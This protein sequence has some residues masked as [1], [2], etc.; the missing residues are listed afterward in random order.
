MEKI[1]QNILQKEVTTEEGQQVE[2]K[3]VAHDP[4]SDEYISMT[5]T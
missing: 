4:L 1:S 2:D 5:S 3:K